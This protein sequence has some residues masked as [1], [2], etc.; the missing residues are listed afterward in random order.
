MSGTTVRTVSFKLW[1]RGSTTSCSDR[2]AKN[3]GR[4][5]AERPV[6]DENGSVRATPAAAKMGRSLS[7]PTDASSAPCDTVRLQCNVLK[8]CNSK[9]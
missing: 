6:I 2:T 9:I 8:R 1:R 4:I 3:L 5:R 7:K